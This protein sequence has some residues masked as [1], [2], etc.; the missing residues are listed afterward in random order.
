MKGL[1]GRGF[2]PPPIQQ[3]SF[4]VQDVEIRAATP[5]RWDDLERLFGPS[6]AYA[7]CWCMFWRLERSKFKH[8]KGE[9]NRQALKDM[10]AEGE[11]PGLLA[12]VGGQVAGWCTIGPRESFAALES[13]RILK[14]VDGAPVWSIACFFVAKP[15][16]RHGLMLA[17]IEG[18]VRH[19]VEQGARIVEAYPIDLQS[20][21]LQDQQLS[22]Y[23][24]YM[25]IA[26]AY[27][28]AGFV[29]VGRAS[30][31]QLI[32]RYTKE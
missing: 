1:V 5:E 20:P 2:V 25:G 13:S 29:E 8:Q 7:G 3:E 28:A 23:S 19:A 21:K 14:R 26:S 11:R 10:V 22:S 17:L 32:M 27:R 30:E 18:A 16:R 31:T 6:G 24:G 4:A 12:Y 9:G 15:F